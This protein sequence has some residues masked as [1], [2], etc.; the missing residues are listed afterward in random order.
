MAK[1]TSKIALE[2]VERIEALKVQI[3][4]VYREAN[5]YDGI[6]TGIAIREILDARESA[7]DQQ[8]EADALLAALDLTEEE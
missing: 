6:N 7:K 2:F 4:E 1:L 8:F 3:A 5:E